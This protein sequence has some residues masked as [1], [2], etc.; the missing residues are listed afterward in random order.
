[1]IHSIHTESITPAAGSDSL[2]CVVDDDESTRRCLERLFRT[3]SYPVKTFASAGEYLEIETHPG[4]VCLVLEVHLP[5]MDGFELQTTLGGRHEQIVFHSSHGDVPM[6]ARAMKAGAVDF[7]TKPADDSL[8]LSAVAQALD[9][10]REVGT[11]R[12]K[13]AAAAE[14]LRSLTPRESQVMRCVTVGMLNKQTSAHLGISEKTVKIH[15]GNLMRKTGTS[16]VPDL[17]WLV[18]KAGDPAAAVPSKPTP[19]TV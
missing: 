18:G 7:L 9:R 12:A 16:S 15:R 10:S 6:C 8:L 4:A 19:C 14:I 17:I 2:V 1:M 11:S 3:A 13:Q 5:G